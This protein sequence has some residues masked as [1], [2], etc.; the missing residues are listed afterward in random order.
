MKVSWASNEFKDCVALLAARDQIML[1]VWSSPLRVDFVVPATPLTPSPLEIR[2]NRVANADTSN[3][4]VSESSDAVAVI[5]RNVPILMAQEIEN[6]T[7]LLHT[8]FRPLGIDIFDDAAGL[9][10]GSSV[11]SGNNFTG[12]SIAIALG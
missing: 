5:W 3:V 9:H 7:V 1:Q 2:G 12:C 10:V 8:D 6:G 11:L 4:R